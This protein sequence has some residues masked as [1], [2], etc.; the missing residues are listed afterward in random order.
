MT[1][2]ELIQKEIEE[3]PDELLGE[4]EEFLRLLKLRA[5]EGRLAPA[6]L[7]ESALRKGWDRPEE[8]EAWKD[9]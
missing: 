6:I 7:S 4:L 3:I 8:D 1:E 9:L 2:K 5:V